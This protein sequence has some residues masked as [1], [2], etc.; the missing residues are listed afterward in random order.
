MTWSAR[1]RWVVGLAA[2]ILLAV[3]GLYLA[4]MFA[5]DDASGITVEAIDS[6]LPGSVRLDAAEVQ[7]EAPALWSAIMEA[8]A[9]GQGWI[10]AAKVASTKLY[11]ESKVDEGRD[12]RSIAIGE[13]GYLLSL[14]SL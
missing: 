12:W 10:P 14:E 4:L 3:A 11:L 13:R 7:R 8:N 6:P 2:G 1:T 5:E 9:T